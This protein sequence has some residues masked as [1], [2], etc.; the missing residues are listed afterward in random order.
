MHVRE[1]CS[2][3]VHHDVQEEH[4]VPQGPEAA[5]QRG[6]LAVQPG[7]KGGQE[8]DQDGRY[9]GQGCQKDDFRLVLLIPPP[10]ALLCN[11]EV[12]E[13]HVPAENELREGHLVLSQRVGEVIDTLNQ[14]IV[15]EDD[16]DRD[17]SLEESCQV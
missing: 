9:D 6:G 7:E 1:H 12:R 8:C 14:G 5:I 16:G 13:G 2:D 3:A 17:Q 15:G 4:Q 11:F 10:P